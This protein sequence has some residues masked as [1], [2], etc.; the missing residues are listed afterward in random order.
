MTSSIL[1]DVKHV[2]GV[3]PSVD[4]FDTD[5]VM[6]INSTFSV[7]TQLGVG[8]ETGFEIADETQTWDQFVTGPRLNWVKTFM[9]LNVKLIFDPPQTGFAIAAIERQIKELE[10]RLNVVSDYG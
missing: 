6:H 8:P 4:A 2:L 10:F 5:I 7:L 3:Q 1:N 9:F